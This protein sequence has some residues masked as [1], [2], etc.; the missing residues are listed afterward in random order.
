[1]RGKPHIERTLESVSTLFCQFVSGYLGRSAEHRGS[2]V[3]DEP[4]WSLLELQE[5]LDE[6]I[7]AVWLHRPHDGLRDPVTPGRAYTPNERYAA[8]V[9]SA[10]YVPV[11]LSAQDYIE[12]LPA[13]WQ[14]INSYGI[15]ISHRVYDS[16]E[17]NPWRRQ[18]SGVTAKKNLWEVHHD[19][20]DV[21]QV[22]VRNHHQG[23]WIT[24]TWKHLDS[25]PAPFGEL[26][27]DH[28]RQHLAAQG[29]RA[30][31]AEIAQAVAALLQR[32]GGGPAQEPGQTAGSP[33]G[34][35]GGSSGWRPAPRPPQRR[36]GRILTH[37]R[38]RPRTRRAPL[39]LTPAPWPR[40]CRCGYSTRERRPAGGGDQCRRRH[41]R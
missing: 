7:L 41:Y 34:R 3:E 15:K 19:P 21:S 16:A 40:W 1:M 13:R 36:P 14:A 35:P 18:P 17:L 30:T 23:G 25:A 24:A 37:R 31:E 39:T 22:W 28:A 11:A 4:L 27:W 20:Y 26:A 9:E 38:R 8:L 2:R 29:R 32:A 12:L 6:W 33:P 10:G 5:L